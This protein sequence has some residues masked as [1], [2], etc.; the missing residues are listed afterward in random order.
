MVIPRNYGRGPGFATINIGFSKTWAFGGFVR[1]KMPTQQAQNQQSTS[2]NK[3]QKGGSTPSGGIAGSGS[4][5]PDA[6]RSDFFGKA[7]EGRYKLTFSIVTRNILNHPNFG[8]P[9]GNLNSRFF[10]R[11]NSIAPPYGYG[12]G[13]DS[14]AANRRIEAQVRFTF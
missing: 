3:P 14:T 4:V 10:G 12:G 7:P 2:K 6:G 8:L 13:G 1:G 11:S 9:I 5:L